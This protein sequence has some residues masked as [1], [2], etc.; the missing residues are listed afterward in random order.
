MDGIRTKE[1]LS[2]ETFEIN[3]A[4]RRGD[5]VSVNG[6]LNVSSMA[7]STDMNF[8]CERIVSWVFELM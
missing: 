8:G 1:L 2:E 4:G 7:I 3:E 5:S 6:N